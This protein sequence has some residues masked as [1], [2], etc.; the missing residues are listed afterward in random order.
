MLAN[1]GPAAVTIARWGLIAGAIHI[2]LSLGLN[3]APTNIYYWY[4]WHVTG[5]YCAYAAAAFL[6]LSRRTRPGYR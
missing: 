4:R 3:L 5:A 2:V 1:R 6:Y